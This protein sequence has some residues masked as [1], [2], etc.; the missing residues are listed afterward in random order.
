VNNAADI[1]VFY[2]NIVHGVAR[3]PIGVAG[4]DIIGKSKKPSRKDDIDKAKA[5]YRQ[6]KIH[7]EKLRENP[8]SLA[9]AHWH[10]EKVNFYNRMNFYFNRARVNP[11]DVID[12]ES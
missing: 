6:Y 5:C 1:F 10:G 7:Q 8:A 3:S 11:T 2:F 12:R 4:T 9:T